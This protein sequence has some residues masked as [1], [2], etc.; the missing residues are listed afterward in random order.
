MPRDG[1]NDKSCKGVAV[2][3]VAVKKVPDIVWLFRCVAS[4]TWPWTARECCCGAHRGS[5]RP[6]QPGTRWQLC[7]ARPAGSRRC[8]WWRGGGR[9]RWDVSGA[10]WGGGG[11]NRWGLLGV[12]GEEEADAAEASIECWVCAPSQGF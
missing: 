2:S 3:G 1:I 9:C 10:G 6:T 7:A 11:R 4:G 8:T 5:P 12:G